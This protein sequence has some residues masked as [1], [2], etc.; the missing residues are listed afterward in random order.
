MISMA[1][2]LDQALDEL[3]AIRSTDPLAHNAVRTVR[4][5]AYTLKWWADDRSPD[6]EWAD[7]GSVAEAATIS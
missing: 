6:A 7:R 5:A 4:L 3:A 1:G 2:D